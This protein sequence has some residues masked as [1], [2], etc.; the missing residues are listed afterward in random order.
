MRMLLLAGASA[1]GAVRLSHRRHGDTCVQ[2]RLLVSP[3]HG[4]HHRH[5]RHPGQWRG[6]GR[7][8]FCSC[9]L[10]AEVEDTFDLTA[11]EYYRSRWAIVRIDRDFGLGPKLFL[12]DHRTL[13][14]T[15]E[16]LAGLGQLRPSVAQL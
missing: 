5:L 15:P 10:G 12:R 7:T 1:A 2:R 4:A 6:W 8:L 11:G 14:T 3:A 13:I 9:G 16:G